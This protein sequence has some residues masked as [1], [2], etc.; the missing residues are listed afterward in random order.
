[1]KQVREFLEANPVQYLATIGRDGDPKCRPFMFCFEKDKKLWFCTSNQKEVYKEMKEHP[2]VE[3]SV[4]N[5]EDYEWLRLRG[6]IVFEDNKDVKE[7]CMVNL[8]V[9]GAYKTADNP[10]LEVFY[11]KDPHGKIEN[12]SGRP[13]YEF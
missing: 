10:E 2:K 4:A 7:C 12:V 11:L 5:K 13:A 8:L 3:I 1:M 9:R 6:E